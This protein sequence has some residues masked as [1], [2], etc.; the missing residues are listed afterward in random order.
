MIVSQIFLNLFIAIIIEAFG[1]QN[2]IEN[3]SLQQEDIE[4]F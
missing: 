1:D 4:C 2:E 3:M